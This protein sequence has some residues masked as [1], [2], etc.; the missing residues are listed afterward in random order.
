MKESTPALASRTRPSSSASNGSASSGAGA[1]R[2]TP[3]AYGVAKVDAP[4]PT[5]EPAREEASEADERAEPSRAKPSRIRGPIAAPPIQRAGARAL[6]FED[7][8]AIRGAAER[9]ISGASGP[10]PHLARIQASFGRFDVGRIAAHTDGAAR[11]GARAMGASAFAMGEHVAF[12]GP[13]SLHTAAHEAAH[14][15]QQQQGVQ[16]EGGVGKVG[17][18][19]ERHADAVADQVVRG[20]SAEPLLG[21][22]AGPGPTGPT[23]AIQRNVALDIAGAAAGNFAWSYMQELIAKFEV[24]KTLAK[25]LESACLGLIDYGVRVTGIGAYLA[26]MNPYVEVLRGIKAVVASIPEPIR[27]LLTYGIGWCIRKFSDTYMFGAITESHINAL[28]IEGGTFL[29]TLGKIIDFLHDLGHNPV[30]A[31][32]TGIWAA[33]GAAG[34]TT[35]R[36]FSELLIA[37]VS[38]PAR[39]SG[40]SSAESVAPKPAPMVDAE[41]G[42]FWLEAANPEIARWTDKEVA[43]GGLQLDARFGIKVFGNVMGADA[44]RIRVPYAGDWE[45]TFSGV[46]LVSEPI[47]LGAFTG[48]PIALQKVRVGHDGLRFLHL[49]IGK[50]AFGDVLTASD[51]SL[52]YRSNAP[53]DMLHFRGATTL[54]AFGHTI[55]GRFD[56]QIDEDGEFAGG[57]ADLVCPETFTLVEDRLTLSNPRL[58]AK[59]SEDGGTDLGIGGDLEIELIDSLEFASTGT[60]LRYATGKGFVGEV[61]KVW[62]NI[63]IHKGGILRFELTK[64][65]IDK[66]GFHAGK[67]ALIYAYGEDDVAKNKDQSKPSGTSLPDS[68]SKLDDSAIT[69]LVPGFDMAWIKTTGLETLVVNLSASDVDID[70]DGLDVGE[71][72]KEITKFKAHLFGLGA[73]FDGVA[74]TGKITGSLRHEIGIPAFIAKF[75]IVP[76]VHAN[77][78]IRTD[79]GFGATLAASLQRLDADVSTPE[80]HPWKLGGKAALEAHAGVQLEAGVG[81]GIPY[82]FDISGNLFARAEG[83][84]GLDADVTGKVLWNDA[85]HEL[86]LPTKP[87]DKP[88][89]ELTAKVGM[90][91]AIGAS[92]RAQLFYFIDTDLWSYRFVEWDLGDWSLSAKLVAKPEGGYEVITTKVG[93]GGDEGQPV[94]KPIVE[95]A[96]VTAT[97]M[98]EDCIL[99]RKKIDDVHQMW[100]LVHDLQDPGFMMDHE[101]KEGY[102]AMLGAI[103]GTDLDLD[104]VSMQVMGFVRQRS[105][106]GDSLLMSR[107]EW[108][109]YSTTGKTFSAAVTE[110]KSIKPID[111]AIA[112]YHDASTLPARQKILTNLID[113]LIPA[114]TGQRLVSRKDMVEKLSTDAK[115]ELARISG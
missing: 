104:A 44:V 34:L 7:P 39:P 67:V 63:P 22:L 65:K 59:W 45:A 58:W 9:G 76:G 106:D 51:L 17:D 48:G 91:A 29:V 94:T 25:L 72:S 107:G 95:K 31:L 105:D 13:P 28:L 69:Q 16:L 36:S 79:I 61:E 68:G 42:W 33:V 98:I 75:P 78:G 11:A 115:R 21:Q 52:T 109:A 6:C 32:Y 108:L 38:K 103:N 90:K 10:L 20:G 92:V 46:S 43:R 23:T 93:F 47:E 86:S 56:L 3:P 83:R 71:L 114:Y 12:A 77:F 57:K 66:T 27:V 35:A 14:V 110:R 102:F 40:P 18:V 96:R 2:L 55:A 64:G 19:Y 111:E 81:V 88:S 97:A 84:V 54:A 112:A 30:S 50:F 87:E 70:S 80:V 85:T 53:S 26:A 82:L 4:K 41:L 113:V 73:E 49:V 5:P 74:R 62:L 15:I 8:R 99:N 1:T 100:R 60:T 37:D 89:A 24:K 101:Q